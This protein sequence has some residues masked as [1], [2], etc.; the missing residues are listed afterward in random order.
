[1]LWVGTNEGLNRFD[2]NTGQWHRYL[3]DPDDPYSISSNI[4]GDVFEDQDGLL[5]IGTFDNGLNRFDPE[6][7][8]FTR[9]QNDPDDPTSFRGDLVTVITQDRQGILWIGSL[10]GELNSY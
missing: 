2:K 6:T 7:E 1:M 3:H 4:V 9:Y 5:W 10:D 8:R